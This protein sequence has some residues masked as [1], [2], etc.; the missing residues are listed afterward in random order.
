[1]EM[2]ALEK[3]PAGA[4]T[5]S[6]GGGEGDTSGCD[7]AIQHIQDLPHVAHSQSE[8]QIGS[9]SSH[10]GA[11]GDDGSS[12]ISTLDRSLAARRPTRGKMIPMDS[13]T[14]NTPVVSA[15]PVPSLE[16]QYPGFSHSQY[17][18]RSMPLPSLTLDRGYAC[19]HRG[20]PWKSRCHCCGDDHPSDP[21]S[22]RK[23]SHPLRS[24]VNAN[25]AAPSIVS[26]PGNSCCGGGS[27][28]SPALLPPPMVAMLEPKVYTSMTGPP[29][30]IAMA[31][32]TASLGQAGKA[33]SPLLPV[34]VPTAPD[35]LEEGGGDKLSG[36]ED[37]ANV[38]EQ[39]DLSEQMA[40]LEGLMK[41][42]NAI[43]GSAF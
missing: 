15:I 21:N 24:F 13:Q 6:L 9:K 26:S 43:T 34:S 4:G 5:G 30:A 39:D 36:T 11:E 25:S 22:L 32:K 17:T 3:G 31:T 16:G 37:A 42:L 19:G 8:S 41:Q 14:A 38:Y 40:S 29:G 23:P 28:G 2:K 20:S 12:S 10:S 33:R 7:T 1:M 35:F 18:L 27:Q